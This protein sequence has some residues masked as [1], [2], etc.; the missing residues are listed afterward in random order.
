[1]QKWKM[2]K[3]GKLFSE[4]RQRFSLRIFGTPQAR[5]AF[6]TDDSQKASK[7]EMVFDDYYAHWG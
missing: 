2:S 7:F 4:R 1:M 6:L 5:I 3:A